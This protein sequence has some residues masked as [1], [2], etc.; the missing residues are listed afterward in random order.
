[1]LEVHIGFVE[2]DDL[3]FVQAGTDL[4]GTLVIMVVLM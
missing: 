4:T 3:A 1:V 2:D